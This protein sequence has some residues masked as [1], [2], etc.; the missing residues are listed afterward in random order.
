MMKS[1]EYANYDAIGLN[2]LICKKQV[3]AKEVLEAAI[4]RCEQVNPDINAVTCKMYDEAHAQLERADKDAPFYGVPF[5]LKD[6]TMNYAGVPTTHGSRL[7]RDYVPNFDSELVKRHKKAGLITIGKSNTPEFG[8]TWITES[9]LL[10][11]C[12]NPY[13]L[14]KT[15]GGSSGGSAAAIAAGIV[16]IAHASDGGGS[17]RVPASCCGLIGL[18]TTR[19]RVPV[20][21][22]RGESGSGMSVHHGLSRT[23]RDCALLLDI[24]KGAEI[25]DPYAAPAA[26]DS[27][28]EAMHAPLPK[29]LKIGLVTKAPGGYAVAQ[30]CLDAVAKTVKLVENLGAVIEE[31]ELTADT[32]ELKLA[33]NTLWTANLAASLEAYTNVTGHVYTENDIEPANFYMA[34]LGHKLKAKDY[35][36]ALS[37]MHQTGRKMG[38]VMQQY[39]L[40]LMPTLA[41]LPVDIGALVYTSDKG[42]V[43]DFYKNKGF[44]FSPFTSLFNVTGQPAISLPLYT[45]KCGLPVGVQFAAAFGNELLLLQLAQVLF[46][47]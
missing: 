24:A 16:P 3:S 34:K 38:N 11:A 12:R 19:A 7:F 35:A 9:L 2:E 25:G 21:P 30:D 26:P 10:G 37:V 42:S 39:D 18:K 20:G 27:Y 40:L 46:P 4:L 22:E 43:N 8:T 5:L 17:I 33:T 6:L 36:L 23:V 13:D 1:D 29:Q 31:M 15:P 47:R 32:D 44:A 41:Q 14:S 28:L 45:S